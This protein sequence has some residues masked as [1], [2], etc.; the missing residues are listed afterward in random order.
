MTTFDVID[1][2]VTYTVTTNNGKVAEVHRTQ[3]GKDKGSPVVFSELP[4]LVQA[5]IESHIE[6]AFN[7][8]PAKLFVRNPN[9]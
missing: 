4:F 3:Q 2:H 7:T 6:E 1:G 8:V 9:L 5:R